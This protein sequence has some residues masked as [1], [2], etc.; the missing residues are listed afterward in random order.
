MTSDPHHPVSHTHPAGSVFRGLI[1]LAR[2]KQWTKGIFVLIG[3]IFAVASGKLGDV[4][5]TE[6]G[7]EVAL[8]FFAFCLA[9]SGCYVFNDLADIERDRMHPRKKN[10]PLASG[11]VPVGA[12][13]VFGVCLLIGSLLCTL[14]L[15]GAAKWWVIGLVGAYITNVMAYSGGLKHIVIVDVLSLSTGFVLRVLG[16]CAAVDV[17]PSTWLLN[18]TLFLSMFL[19]FGKRLGERRLMG[20][21]ESA[22]AARDVQIS[23]TDQLLRMM[24]VV[25]GVATLLT[26]TG[27]VQSREEDLTMYFTHRPIGLDGHGFGFN[28]LWVSV[29]PATLALLRTITLLM[30]GTYDDP[31]ELALRD[32]M[33]RVSGLLFVL[34][35][36]IVL[37][38]GGNF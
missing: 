16:G 1:R 6:L 22:I 31:T 21:D 29:L 9:A 13:K 36:G 25:T 7:L 17:A 33:V 14:A 35:T 34:V 37:W 3:P 24:V 32:Q 30:R 28:L 38:I 10:R 8:A 4:P 27:Y 12:A 20:S 2:L 23:Y 15:P 26:Y 19:A 5:R 18:A 11:Q